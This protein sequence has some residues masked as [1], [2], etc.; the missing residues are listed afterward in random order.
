MARRKPASRSGRRLIAA[1]GLILLIGAAFFASF[2]SP[3]AQVSAN[4]VT[5][6]MTFEY[7]PIEAT[8]T[9]GAEVPLLAGAALEELGVG[10]FE[11]L[12]V[13][14]GTLSV[15][16][17]DDQ[18]WKVVPSSGPVFVI[19]GDGDSAQAIFPGVTIERWAFGNDPTVALGFPGGQPVL[20]ALV[21]GK[22]ID[23]FFDAGESVEF[24]CQMCRIETLDVAPVRKVQVSG[25]NRVAL[26]ASSRTRMVLNAT[27]GPGA[28]GNQNFRMA[29]IRFCGGKGREPA[30]TIVDGSV[31]FPATGEVHS[32]AG[33]AGATSPAGFLRL[34]AEE[35]FSVTAL[36]VADVKGQR[37]LDVQFE[38]LAHSAEK[39]A[40][41]D[42]RATP[43]QPSYLEVLKRQ[44][45]V[46]ATSAALALLFGWLGLF[47][48]LKDLWGRIRGK[49]ADK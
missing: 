35:T 22:G 12:T 44:P 28:F 37:A 21:Q 18:P 13:P 20:R 47:D 8:P 17:S 7:Y 3:H 10:S 33:Q 34:T 43:F 23:L 38:G 36:R 2:R 14:S 15:R 11:T 48:Q 26:K 25:L 27:P 40:A 31:T 4:V 5:T 49:E 46:L 29:R 6:A 45:V 41:C 24:E 19:G 1:A 42:G 30:S 16:D 32:L 9:L 39:P